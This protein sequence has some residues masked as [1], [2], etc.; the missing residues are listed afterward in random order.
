MSGLSRIETPFNY[1]PEETE[2]IKQRLIARIEVHYNLNGSIPPMDSLLEK[3]GLPALKLRHL[4]K[5]EINPKLE[6]RG[7]PTY[8]EPKEHS[9]HKRLD[10]L[11][12]DPKFVLACNQILDTSSNKSFNARIKELSVLGITTNTWNNW[13]KDERYYLY[14]Q[15]VF[16]ERFDKTLDMQADMALAR[17]IQS[18]DLQSIKYYKELTGKFRPHDENQVALAM[19]LKLTMEIISRHVPSNV[20]DVIAEEIESS[21]VGMLLSGSD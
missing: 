8:V 5:T 17:N 19:L 20:I 21:P 18:G 11:D 3:S 1:K 2:S 12:F 4:I 6:A 9:I 10:D 15:K 13:M 16:N 7:I 14:A